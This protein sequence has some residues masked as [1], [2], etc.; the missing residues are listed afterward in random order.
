MKHI[1][2]L[3]LTLLLTACQ[4]SKATKAFTFDVYHKQNKVAQGSFS[5]PQ[6]VRKSTFKGTWVINRL[7][8][9]KTNKPYKANISTGYGFL[10]GTTNKRLHK[11]TTELSF[12]LSSS[13]NQYF[14]LPS[15]L[16]TKNTQGN[17]TFSSCFLSRQGQIIITG[18]TNNHPDIK[19]SSATETYLIQK[20]E[21][22]AFLGKYREA[23]KNK[24]HKD[25]KFREDKKLQH[26][27]QKDYYDKHF[28]KKQ[29]AKHNQKIS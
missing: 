12:N 2:L 17:W 23:Y 11:Y 3:L 13:T 24:Y 6:E 21:K 29:K 7:N 5:M 20:N 1:P 10:T 27:F 9:P 25:P 28:Y 19:I 16:T 26:K 8:N 4:N 22:E 18:Q 14:T 15:N